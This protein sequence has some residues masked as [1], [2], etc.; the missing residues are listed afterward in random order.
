MYIDGMPRV[1][2]LAPHAQLGLQ[3]SAERRRRLRF[4]VVACRHVLLA[5]LAPP[6]IFIK[7][8]NGLHYHRLISTLIWL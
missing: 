5:L 7:H 3:S 8:A 4:H 1:G 2:V 6:L